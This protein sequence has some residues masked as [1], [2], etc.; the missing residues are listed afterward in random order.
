MFSARQNIA[1]NRC[2]I[3]DKQLQNHVDF[4][5]FCFRRRMD[6]YIFN[7]SRQKNG[8]TKVN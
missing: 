6:F 5:D 4:Q 8:F 7:N 3:N 1:K 2:M